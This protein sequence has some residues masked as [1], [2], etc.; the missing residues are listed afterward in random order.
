MLEFSI[1][2]NQFADELRADVM[3]GR[4]REHRVGQVER[5]RGTMGSIPVVA[6]TRAPTKAVWNLH[7]R[8]LSDEAILESYPGLAADD[9]R[10]AIGTEERRRRPA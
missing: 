10:A 6:G 7:I 5:R 2:L 9:V 8:G 4:L 3:K 1:P